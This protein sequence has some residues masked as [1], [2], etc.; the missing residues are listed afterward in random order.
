MKKISLFI[1]FSLLCPFSLVYAMP[2]CEECFL[3]PKE[4]GPLIQEKIF[5]KSPLREEDLSELDL[6]GWDLSNIDLRGAVL[7]KLK[8]IFIVDVLLE[9]ANLE[10]AIVT[11]SQAELL[12]AQGLSGFVIVE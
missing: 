2:L 3:A 10:G 6:R 9:G 7:I 4:P 5:N 12:K 8:G 1:I 11:S